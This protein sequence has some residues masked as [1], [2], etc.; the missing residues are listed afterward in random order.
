MVTVIL[1]TICTDSP[2]VTICSEFL[3]C[4]CV[5]GS[6]ESHSSARPP[7]CRFIPGDGSCLSAAPSWS[8]PLLPDHAKLW[9]ELLSKR[10]VNLQYVFDSSSG[11]GLE[12]LQLEGLTLSLANCSSFLLLPT[13]PS[14][15]AQEVPQTMCSASSPGHSSHNRDLSHF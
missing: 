8:G 1:L 15:P 7:H 10:A 9:A 2:G 5:L 6:L 14:Q 3:K 13:C 4:Q 12:L 11:D